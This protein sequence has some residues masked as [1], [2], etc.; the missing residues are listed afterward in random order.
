MKIALFGNPNTGKSSVFNM[1]TGL[2]Q[3]VGNFPGVTVEK[4]SG[5][6]KIAD[7]EY[8]LTDFPG[9]YSIY[10]R[11]KDEEVV[12]RV[13][14]DQSSKEYPELAL[15]ILN[16]SQLKRNLL[17]CSQLYDLKIPLIIVVNMSDIAQRKG[18]S[19][20]LEK[21]EELFPG[22]A[23]VST[24]ARIGIGKDRLLKAISNFDFE[25]YS[26]NKRLV[27][28]NFEA[29]SIEDLTKQVSETKERTDWIDSV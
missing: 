27:L 14:T 12:Y 7:K 20:D 24:N 17:L 6:F 10:P 5:L 9:T 18:I 1:L 29:A 26:T 22:C 4:K 16:A 23:V 21:L 2:R 13:L 28:T 15:V 8:T 19:I 3:Q 25:K 11:T